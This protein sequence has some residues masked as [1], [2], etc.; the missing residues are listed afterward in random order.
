MGLRI[1]PWEVGGGGLV[2]I[3]AP[4]PPYNGPSVMTE[5]NLP[6]QTAGKLD[7]DVVQRIE[8]MTAWTLKTAETEPTTLKNLVS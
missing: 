2:H 4:P 8:T 3:G 7:S 6:F 1:A 5:K